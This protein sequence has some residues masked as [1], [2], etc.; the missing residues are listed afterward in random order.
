MT[1]YS[2][3]QPAEVAPHN[4]GWQ[5]RFNIAEIERE[6]E[7]GIINEWQF[8]YINV[9]IT[10]NTSREF[11][12][13]VRDAKTAAILVT[14]SSG[15]TFDG[16]EKSQERMARAIKAAEIVGQTETTWVLA[17]NSAATVTLAEMLEAL[18]LAIQ[19]QSAIWFE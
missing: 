16:D 2:T 1:G 18:A 3:Q 15:K 9:P 11:R 12:K 13:F 17:D 6:T 8:D 5:V 19:A 7:E 4:A 14:V 10:D